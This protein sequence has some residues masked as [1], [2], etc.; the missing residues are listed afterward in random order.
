M[1]TE[2]AAAS[3][4]ESD[5]NAGPEAAVGIPL[6]SSCFSFRWPLLNTFVER[7]QRL[8]CAFLNIRVFSS[9]ESEFHPS[10]TSAPRSVLLGS[11]LRSSRVSARGLCSCF[12]AR[13]AL[14]SYG[15]WFL[16]SYGLWLSMTCSSPALMAFGP[17]GLWFFVSYGLRLL[18]PPPPRLLGPWYGEDSVSWR[19]VITHMRTSPAVQLPFELFTTTGLRI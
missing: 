15:L 3:D 11:K 1:E 13:N 2:S 10:K 5:A 9:V 18:W 19:N 8:V 12:P 14:G 4:A 6:A 17:C 7:G 16:G